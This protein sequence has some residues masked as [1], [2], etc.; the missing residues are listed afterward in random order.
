MFIRPPA[1]GKV[2]HL[3]A[4]QADAVGAAADAPTGTALFNV[5]TGQDGGG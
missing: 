1:Q 4:R 2:P 3:L 5:A